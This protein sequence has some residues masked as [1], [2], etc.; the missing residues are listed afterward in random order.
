MPEATTRNRALVQEIER[1]AVRLEDLLAAGAT[2]LGLTGDDDAPCADDGGSCANAV[3]AVSLPGVPPSG[4]I[5][6]FQA[7][8]ACRNARKR[9]PENAEWQAAVAGTP[10]PGADDGVADCNTMAAGAV[11]STGSRARCVS[12]D[13]AFDLVGN[14]YEGEWAPRSSH[15]TTW[16]EASPTG[17]VQCLV[18]AEIT[19]EPGALLR[20]GSYL[21]G[22]QAGPLAIEGR[23]S[24]STAAYGI[25]L[26]CAR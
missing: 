14:A 4:W 2:Q 25:G 22:E 17:D 3:Y 13:G 7:Q 6:W 11:V 26:R 16:A 9:L 8:A 15:C 10:D 24:P 21:S 5:T 19:G 20:G 23:V 1:G 18:G 12:A